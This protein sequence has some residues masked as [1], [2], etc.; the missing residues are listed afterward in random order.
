MVG[1]DIW[2]FGDLETEFGSL[3]V[4]ID[5]GCWAAGVIQVLST[6]A[7]IKVL[8][9]HETFYHP[10]GPASP[11]NLDYYKGS[12]FRIE[13]TKTPNIQSKIV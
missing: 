9:I 4:Q 1:F 5:R 12:K 6:V 10:D 3:M 11:I 8:A 7:V 13:T 2:G